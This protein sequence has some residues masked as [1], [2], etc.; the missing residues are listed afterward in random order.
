VLP[1][2]NIPERPVYVNGQTYLIGSYNGAERGGSE[3]SVWKLDEKTGLAWPVAFVGGGTAW[4][5][6]SLDGMTGFPNKPVEDAIAAQLKTLGGG[7]PDAF[8]SWADLNG[9]HRSDPEEWTVRTF[10]P[11]DTSYTGPDGKPAHATFFSGA[12]LSSTDLSYTGGWAVTVPAPTFN[13]DGIPIYDIS[14]AKINLPPQPE[15]RSSIDGDVANRFD[16]APD[17]WLLLWP[18]Y[19]WKNGVL[20]WTYPQSDPRHPPTGPGDMEAVNHLMGPLVTPKAGDAGP[21]AFMENDKGALYL[22]TVDGFFVQ[23]FGGD[24][25]MGHLLNLPEARRGTFIDDYSFSSEHWHTTV[26]QF[27]DGRICVVAGKEFCGIFT[28]LGLE[29]VHR[30]DFGTVTV[31]PD[32]L[33]AL[34]EEQVKPLPDPHAPRN[35][36]GVFKTIAV[37]SVDHA[38]TIDGDLSDWPADTQWA[39]I[40]GQGQGAICISGDQLCAAWKTNDPN[41]LKNAGGQLPFLFKSGGALDLMLSTNLDRRSSFAPQEGDL[42]LLVTMVNGKTQAALYRPVKPDASKDEQVTF[43]SPV[44]SVVFDSVTDVSEQVQVAQQG[45]NYELSVPLSVLGLDPQKLRPGST[46]IRG[47]IGLLRGEGERTVERV[48]WSNDDTAIVSDV[49]SEARL[50]PAN[51][52]EFHLMAKP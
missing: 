36:N 12:S 9:N 10:P 44:G 28:V 42:R 20:Q 27:D 25:R 14:K 5:Q 37:A 24:E 17:G 4:I 34:P 2:D 11:S 3:G 46:V 45:S 52:G 49:P 15:F 50:Q 16:S 30:V 29:S 23:A 22:M 40:G 51:W 18:K 32:Q 35:N 8:L 38:P 33:A 26:T 47:D 19:G 39:S 48:Y 7:W 21:I 13:S 6:R 41:L 1:E 31:T 43:A